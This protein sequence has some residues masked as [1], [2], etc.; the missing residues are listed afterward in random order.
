MILLIQ[1]ILKRLQCH[2]T[3]KQSVQR[4]R[5][6]DVSFPFICLIPNWLCTTHSKKF[7][8]FSIPHPDNLVCFLD[9]DITPIVVTPKT[10]MT[11]AFYS[12]TIRLFFINKEFS[13][14]AK[15]ITSVWE[16][17][18]F[19][20]KMFLKLS[21]EEENEIEES[22]KFGSKMCWQILQWWWKHDGTLYFT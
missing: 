9:K 20:K 17:N 18:W 8:H 21:K 14:V 19:A 1:N 2:I 5:C 6:F 12:L 13:N 10:L 3:K 11:R 22:L 15:M 16:S 4:N 7:N